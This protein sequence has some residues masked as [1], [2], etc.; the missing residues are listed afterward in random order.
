MSAGRILFIEDQFDTL[1][2]Y[3]KLFK[4]CSLVSDDEYQKIS[5]FKGD[6]Q[7]EKFENFNSVLGPRIEAATCFVDAFKKIKSAKRGTEYD[8]FFI[9]RNLFLYDDIHNLYENGDEICFYKNFSREFFDGFEFSDVDNYEKNKKIFVGD[10][11]IVVLI[12]AGVPIEKICFLT[13]NNDSSVENLLKSPF[14]H[15]EKLP[16]VIDKKGQELEK[17]LGE[18]SPCAK[19]R[20]LYRDIFHNKKV[21][22]VFGPYIEDFISILAKHYKDGKNVQYNQKAMASCLEI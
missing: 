7:K 12:N 16:R 19:I 6:N 18:E 13:A 17:I 15:G 21:D 22:D 3:L 2:G 1:K 9:D 11:L 5:R 10:Y 4:E 8:W 20:F 14:L